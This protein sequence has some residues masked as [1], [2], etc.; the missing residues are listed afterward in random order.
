M[1]IN[2][3]LL[4]NRRNFIGNNSE[5]LLNIDHKATENKKAAQRAAF[6]YLATFMIMLI[7]DQ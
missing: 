5:M 2:S 4:K 6:Q 1:E 3:K 7:Q